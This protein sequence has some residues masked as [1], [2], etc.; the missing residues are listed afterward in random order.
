[1]F[2]IFSRDKPEIA[3]RMLLSILFQGSWYSVP[4]LP[5]RKYDMIFIHEYK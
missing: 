2:P 3:V 1:M 5:F 4:E